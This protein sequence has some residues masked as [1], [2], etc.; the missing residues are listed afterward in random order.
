MAPALASSSRA[1]TAAGSAATRRSLISSSRSRRAVV[2]AVAKEQQQQIAAPTT[3]VAASRRAA[4]LSATSLLLLAPTSSALANPLEDATRAYLRPADALTDEQA[5]AALLDARSTLKDL[6]QL[7]ATPLDSRERF[8]GRKLWPAFARWLRPAGPAAP[9]V[10]SL[11]LG[12]KDA[13]ATLSARYG[14]AAAGGAGEEAGAP[15]SSSSSSSQPQP[16]GDELYRSLGAVL[17]I[18]GR[19]IREEAQVSPDRALR[20]AAAI[21][22]VLERVPQDVKEGAQQLRVAARAA[23]GK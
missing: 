20:A 6:A 23:R 1:A 7:A 4:L 2:L 11:A 18:S 8:D 12:G 22:G 17:T 3:P 15:S 21:D 16:L 13:E 5:V 19:T 14:G 9:R 10:V